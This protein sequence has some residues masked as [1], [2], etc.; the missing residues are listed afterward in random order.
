M[1]HHANKDAS[2]FELCAKQ[3][4]RA[5]V[6]RAPRKVH[7][8]LYSHLSLRKAGRLEDD[9][10]ENYSEDVIVV[11]LYRT[12][13]GHD[14]VRRSARILER[15]VGQASFRY[16]RIVVEDPVGYLVW[17]ADGSTADVTEGVDSFL[18]ENGRIKAQTIYYRTT[19]PQTVDL[20]GPSH[21]YRTL[22]DTR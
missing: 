21:K 7:D 8:V 10:R 22:E 1:R 4:S 19:S 11:D 3:A 16:K 18:I 2:D 6:V 17:S 15:S 14:G 20:D 13:R 9:L 12:Y 5:L